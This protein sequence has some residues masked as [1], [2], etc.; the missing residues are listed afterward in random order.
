MPLVFDAAIHQVIVFTDRA[1]IARSGKIQLPAGESVLVLAG[2]TASLENDSV[3][4]NGKGAGITIRGVDVKQDVLA[5]SK[6]ELKAKL[7][8]EVKSLRNTLREL[9]HERSVN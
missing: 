2:L 5:E 6:D 7:Q 8:E 1:R 9:E 4:V 3:R